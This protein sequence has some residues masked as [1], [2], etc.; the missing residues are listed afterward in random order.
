VGCSDCG[1]KGGCDARKHVQRGVLDGAV[2]RVYPDRTWGRLDDE[3]RF[4]AGVP[5][6]EV[7]R[8]SRSIAVVAR[9]EVT[10][11]PGEPEDLC[12]FVWVLC[13]GRRPSLLEIRE[14]APVG[15]A[16]LVPGVRVEERWL[17]LAISSVT[18]AAAMQEVVLTMEVDDDGNALVAEA[19]RAG[20]FDPTLLSRVQAIVAL[21]EASD[22]A[23]ID[24][25]LLDK[26]LAGGQPGDYEA[27]YG[28]PPRLCNYLFFAAPPTVRTV[29]AVAGVGAAEVLGQREQRRVAP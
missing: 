26:P 21:L 16:D 17:R 23:H 20:V 29:S 8:L 19:P 28:C 10:F 12:D 13:L 14:G 25:G 5:R 24:F 6:D 22:V 1:S 27:R 4:G 15:E 9:A 2:D 18:R 11:R 7:R 3:A